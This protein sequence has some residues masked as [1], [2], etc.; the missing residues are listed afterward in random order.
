[1]PYESR[2]YRGL[3]AGEVYEENGKY[4]CGQDAKT[5]SPDKP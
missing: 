2:G 5:L 1:L 3:I 4:F